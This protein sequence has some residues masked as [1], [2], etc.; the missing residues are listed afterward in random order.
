MC[1]TFIDIGFQVTL[2][3]WG[4]FFLVH[5]FSQLRIYVVL[6]FIPCEITPANYGIPLQ[7][8]V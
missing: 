7:L 6:C 5:I 2:V 3:F 1:P 8:A 4:G